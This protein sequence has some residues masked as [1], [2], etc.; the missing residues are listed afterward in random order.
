MRGCITL[1]ETMKKPPP[2]AVRDQPVRK[3]RVSFQQAALPPGAVLAVNLTSGSDLSQPSRF[4][5]AHYREGRTWPTWLQL[6]E[7]KRD[8]VRGDGKRVVGRFQSLGKATP[9]AEE[10]D[11]TDLRDL[12]ATFTIDLKDDLSALVANSAAFDV[13]IL[14]EQQG[15]EE[16]STA[17]KDDLDLRVTALSGDEEQATLFR[18]HH[19][20]LER[21]LEIAET[22]QR[23]DRAQ[24]LL[25]APEEQ[26]S[27]DER[28]VVARLR[29][30]E[31]V[32]VVTRAFGAAPPP[33]LAR[34]K[35]HASAIAACE[36]VLR[37][38]TPLVAETPRFHDVGMAYWAASNLALF[39]ETAHEPE[40]ARQYGET[41]LRLVEDAA[42]RAPDEPEFSRWVASAR[43]R[44]RRAGRS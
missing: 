1:I 7:P 33:P 44:L 9:L 34:R 26:L 28:R 38:L 30:A 36:A 2:D 20:P 17:K 27:P 35:V 15:S 19:R 6:E 3:L 22:Q 10:L 21:E 18:S 24:A 16:R 43:D 12:P 31:A 5:F 4:L 37:L 23:R 8:E 41:A 42:A 25:G 13:T 39:H 14:H 40:K 29:H 11:E 32:Q